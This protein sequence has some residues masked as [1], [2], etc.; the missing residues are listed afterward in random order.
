MP[1]DDAWSEDVAPELFEERV[2]EIVDEAW[3]DLVAVLLDGAD[4]AAEQILRNLDEAIEAEA[5]RAAATLM[6][7]L[8]AFEKRELVKMFREY[9]QL[10]LEE[11]LPDLAE[12]IGKTIEWAIKKIGR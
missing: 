5:K 7:D 10:T 6:R 8:K 9:L 11:K 3:D 12:K 4:N 2:P 1:K